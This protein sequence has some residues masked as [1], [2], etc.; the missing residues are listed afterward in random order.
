[1]TIAEEVLDKTTVRVWSASRDTRV[2]IASALPSID[3]GTPVV[4]LIQLLN[5]PNLPRLRVFADELERDWLLAPRIDVKWLNIGSV[6]VK[7]EN[8]KFWN[9]PVPAANRVQIHDAVT[10]DGFVRFHSYL[11][12]KSRIRYA[13]TCYRFMSQYVCLWGKEVKKGEIPLEPTPYVEPKLPGRPK[14]PKPVPKSAIDRL[15]EDELI[16]E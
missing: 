5:Q 9:R 7:N 13:D 3:G 1:M 10:M 4:F 2:G 15:L 8:Q 11:K 12:G 16:P 14:K 6:W